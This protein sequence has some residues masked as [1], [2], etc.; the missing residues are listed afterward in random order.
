[1]ICS[2]FYVAGYICE[3]YIHKRMVSGKRPI[4]AGVSISF[5]LFIANVNDC[6]MGDNIYRYKGL[7]IFGALLATYFS[8]YV[9]K[10][11]DGKKDTY[12]VKILIY[13][14]KNS[15]DIVIWHFLA[16]KV[17]IIIQIIFLDAGIKEIVD[18]P[19]Y[20]TS[21]GWWLVYLVTGLLGSLMWKYVLE[22]NFVTKILR[23]FYLIR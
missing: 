4:L 11:L 22:H 17:A 7:F 6:N 1:M 3:K 10:M 9:S 13:L 15:F 23:K 21:N 20:Y 8:L 19:T 14:G 18:F 16:F 2:L 12:F 5:Y